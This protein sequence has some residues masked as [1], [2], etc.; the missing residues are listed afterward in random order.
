MTN[1]IPTQ[2]PLDL[3]MQPHF[4]EEDYFVC[5][6]NEQA[7][8]LI[9]TWPAWP[10]NCVVLVGPPASGKSHLAAIWC[11]RSGARI[12]K[13]EALR[14][15]D[16]RDVV[17]TGAVLIERADKLTQSQPNDLRRAGEAAL[18]HLL[19]LAKEEGIFVLITAEEA[20]DSWGLQTP[21]VLSRLRLAPLTR[22]GMPSE[23]MLRA[24]LVKHFNDRQIGVELGVV[25]WLVRRMARSFA[26]ARDVVAALDREALANQAPITRRL[27]AKVL[28]EFGSHDEQ[29]SLVLDLQG[30]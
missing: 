16:L 29:G 10:H 12:F 28:E 17:A 30:K 4:G 8:S 15:Y 22:L 20:P 24:L 1:K 9:T 18:F 19:N 23:L 25:E 3:A 5:P 26:L 2:L 27:A 6:A 21:D 14:D 11:A 7:F 13:A